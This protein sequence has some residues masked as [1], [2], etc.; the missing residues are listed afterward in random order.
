[1]QKFAACPYQ[2]VLAAIHRLEPRRDAVPI[3]Q[4]DPLTRGRIFHHAQSEVLRRLRDSGELP[5]VQ[6]SVEKAQLI[7]DETLDRLAAA[8]R[9]DLAP[10]IERIWDDE[11]DAMRADLRRWLRALVR[12]STT[13]M[14]LH[15]ELTFGLGGVAR[16][17]PSKSEPGGR[18]GAAATA[19]TERGSPD[20]VQLREGYLLRGAVDLVEE[21]V[22]ESTLRITDHKTGRNRTVPGLIVGGGEI[23]QPVLYALAVQQ[24]L[25]RD[26]GEGRLYYCTSRGG[27]TERVVP[28][29]DFAH[30]YADMVLKTLD[31]SV[32]RGF[33][34]PAPRRDACIFCDFRVVCGPHE[35]V[36]SRRKAASTLHYLDEL[37][38]LP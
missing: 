2:F 4:L 27:F 12:D 19:F 38:S 26:V 22:A 17:D 8:Y 6:G 1:L 25:R 3:V 34:P 21:N 37:R 28:I 31:R 14:P 30:L 13:W 36:R 18:A 7:L 35:E 24:L 29:G 9:D 5:A 16:S 20:A 10:A 11:I 32:E 33:L 23:L 15:F